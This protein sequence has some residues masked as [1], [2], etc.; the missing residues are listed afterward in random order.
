M[1]HK[2]N[3]ISGYYEGPDG[4]FYDQKYDQIF[5]LELAYAQCYRRGIGI[6]G[7]TYDYRVIQ[8]KIH[9]TTIVCGLDNCIRLGDL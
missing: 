4:I 3:K 9:K 5:E 2:I 6:V 8:S 1:K 7:N